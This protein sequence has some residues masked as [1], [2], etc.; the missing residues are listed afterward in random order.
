[1]CCEDAVAAKLAPC[2]GPLQSPAANEQH[3]LPHRPCAQ[4]LVSGISQAL[5]S[6]NHSDTESSGAIMLTRRR[7][8]RIT[9]A[10]TRE[11]SSHYTV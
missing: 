9:A 2:S 10:E 11:H 8:G 6:L 1:M 3:M 4:K 5:L 7:L